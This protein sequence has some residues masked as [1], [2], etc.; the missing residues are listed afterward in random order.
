MPREMSGRRWTVARCVLWVL[1]SATP[2]RAALP[3]SATSVRILGVFDDATGQPLAGAEV[4]D[5]ATGTK[6]ITSATGTISLAWLAPGTTILQVRRLGFQSQMLPV[7]TSAA[8]TVSVTVVLKPLAQTLPTVV[9]K[10]RSPGDTVRRLELAGFYDRRRSTGAPASAF[11]TAEDLAKW[12]PLL[13]SDIKSRTGR[14]IKGTCDDLYLDGIL[15]SNQ[16]QLKLLPSFK[17]GI[18]A[19]VEPDQVAGVEIYRMSEAP[20]QYNRRPARPC[21]PDRNVI[22][23]WL[24]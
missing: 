10:A 4:V 9:T 18:D 17:S 24:K 19:L 16:A 7:S 2:V 1:L 22:L 21:P 20:A 6:A 23:I 11:V 15:L 8:D 13:L 3:Q 14:S 5:L 12:K